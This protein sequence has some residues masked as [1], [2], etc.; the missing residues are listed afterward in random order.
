MLIVS[1]QHNETRGLSIELLRHCD[2]GINVLW[3]TVDSQLNVAL[4]Q[5][6]D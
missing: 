2:D 6:G 4:H 3:P 1:I 5:A